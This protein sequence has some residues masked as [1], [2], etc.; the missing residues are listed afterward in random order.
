MKKVFGIITLALTLA[1][2]LVSCNKSKTD[3]SVDADG[4][5][6]VDG[7]N[8]NIIADKEDVITV[9][10][11]GYVVV[12]G[13]K[14]EHK[15]HTADEIAISDDGYLVVNGVKTEYKIRTTDQISVSADGYVVVNGI[16]TDIIADKND[17]ITVDADGNVVVNGVKTEYKAHIDFSTLTYA[18]LGDSITY[19]FDSTNG[20]LQMANPYP[21]LVG[22]LLGLK[23]V[24]NYGIS[25]STLTT[26][27]SFRTPMPDRYSDMTD[28]ADIVSVMG[29]INDYI[30][31]YAYLGDI[32]S[33]DTTTIYGALNVLASGLKAKYPD[34]YIFFMT[35]FKWAGDPG[36]CAKGYSLADVVTAIKKVCSK[37]GIDVLDI[38]SEG[39]YELEMYLPTNDGVHPSQELF[40]KYTAPQIAAFI[41]KNI[42]KQKDTVI[43]VQ[44]GY[45][46]VNGV[47]TEYR[48]PEEDHDNPT[49][50]QYMHLSFD[51]VTLCFGNLAS[52]E[53]DSLFDEPFF[54]KLKELHDEYG[55]RISLYTY[56]D[57]L[58]SV[59][60]TYK[61]EFANNS[62][63]LKL[64]FH[65]NS[66]GL[67]LGNA[68][69]EQGLAYWNTFVGNVERICGTTDCLDRIP[70][71]EYFAGSQEALFGM[72]DATLG[73]LGF[74][75]ADDNRL[76]YYFDDNVMTHL[77]DNDHIKDQNSNLIF[78]STDLRSDWFYSFSTTN[79]YKNPLKSNIKDEL[80]YRNNSVSFRNTS[81]TLIVFAH[82][83]LVYNGSAVN[84]KFDTVTGAC[85]F[86]KAYSIPFDYAQNRTYQDSENDSLFNSID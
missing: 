3:V 1:C 17:V 41:K 65:S 85:E 21:N 5:V 34:S 76:S 2:M 51:D 73:A 72:R 44:D 56:N 81:K 7:V 71:L 12:N 75:S 16:T 27:E 74:L 29:G 61:D 82:E 60:D 67:S 79:V 40:E 8:T 83:W 18:A 26:I 80:I 63:W 14:T 32:D 43:S 50:T 19:G 6:I 25:G 22:E 42:N 49:D 38:Y 78:I 10:A 9:D 30:L 57:V 15:I 23:A 20:G 11:D 35:P 24:Y 39:K 68:T 53:Y 59:P 4:Y 48:I 36:V 55:A 62:D 86:A 47:K 28:Y 70:R 66:S 84:S 69:Y 64:G 54:G 46:T 52:G 58:A 77:F 13:V 31:G 45:L 33:T 37:Y